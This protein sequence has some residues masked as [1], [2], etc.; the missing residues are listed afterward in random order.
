MELYFDIIPSELNTIILS[1]L[2]YEKL[3]DLDNIVKINYEELFAIR[4]SKQYKDIKNIFRVDKTL[5]KYK[6]EW[7]SL[8]VNYSYKINEDINYYTPIMSNVYYTVKI[9]NK[10]KDFFWIKENLFNKGLNFDKLAYYIYDMLKTLKKLQGLNKKFN[11]ES[12]SSINHKYILLYMYEGSIIYALICFIFFDRP[13]NNFGLSVKELIRQLKL[14]ISKLYMLQ[15]PD[16]KDDNTEYMIYK[17]IVDTAKEYVK[18]N[19]LKK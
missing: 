2:H 11:I 7:D 14:G 1:Y 12:L 5:E 8:Y 17:N 13:S 19:E 4:F 16:I 10:Y 15:Y 6:N 9:Y 3:L 18:K